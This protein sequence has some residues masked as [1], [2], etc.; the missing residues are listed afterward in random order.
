MTLARLL[1]CDAS[2]SGSRLVTSSRSPAANRSLV[3]VLR[4]HHANAASSS[5]K[6]TQGQ[7]CSV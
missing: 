1:A 5:L 2:H 4:L 7:S 3:S 6:V